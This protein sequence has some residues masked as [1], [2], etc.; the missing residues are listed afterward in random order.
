MTI[1]DPGEEHRLPAR[2]IRPRRR[3]AATRTTICITSP[4]EDIVAPGPTS[5]SSGASSKMSCRCRNPSANVAKLRLADASAIAGF[6]LAR[7]ASPS[8][9]PDEHL[10][11][12]LHAR[13]SAARAPSIRSR[14]NARN[15]DW[16][17]PT[18]RRPQACARQERER[19]RTDVAVQPRHRLAGRRT[20][21]R[22]PRTRSASFA[23]TGAN[24][25]GDS[26]QVIGVVGVGHDDDVAGRALEA[27][28]QGG[29]VAADRSVD[30]ARAGRR[31]DL[32]G[33]VGRPVVD[34]DDL[35]AQSRRAARCQALRGR[36]SRPTRPRRGR[37]TRLILE[38]PLVPRSV[39]AVSWG[40][41]IE[42]R[43]ASIRASATVG[44]AV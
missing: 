8:A 36:R 16:L 10:A 4:S 14:R 39:E 26:S 2:A 34:D 28:E 17:S 29:A 25:I 43:P 42:I 44:R 12:E 13:S 3:T 40:T 6:D 41:L 21:A 35:G 27:A 7:S 32:R 18:T 37:A 30:D 33:S 15:P 9:P 1:S 24:E 19:R 20:R 23:R 22:E 31:G 38:R 5:S 11:R